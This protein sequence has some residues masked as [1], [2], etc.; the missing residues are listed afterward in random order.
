MLRLASPALPVGGFA[1]SS[2]LEGAIEE[3][4]VTAETAASHLEDVLLL[5]QARWDGP[6]LWRMLHGGRAA[7][8]ARYLASRETRELR[9]E[10]LQLGG[11]LVRLLVELEGPH[12]V[13]AP[14]WKGRAGEGPPETRAAT[15]ISGPGLAHRAPPEPTFPCAWA[16]AAEAWS[17]PADAALLAWLMAFLENQLAVLQKALPLGQVAAQRLLQG[18]LPV[19][20]EAHA[21][22]MSLPDGAL[23]SA[24][25]GLALLSSRHET[26]YSRLFRS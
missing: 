9:M 13:S 7:W 4:L 21:L 11:S 25:P 5:G 17:I 10:T 1:W 18:L 14:G 2:G 23:C 20:S 15:E 22:A 26:Q 12:A 16:L 3:G 8:N 19:V 6:V 24:L